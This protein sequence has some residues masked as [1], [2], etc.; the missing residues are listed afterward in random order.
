MIKR[1]KENQVIKRKESIPDDV[2]KQRVEHRGQD[3]DRDAVRVRK[4]KSA[5]D[6]KFRCCEGEKEKKKIVRFTNSETMRH[7]LELSEVRK[8]CVSEAMSLR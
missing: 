8:A 1:K 7:E 6:L 2:E 5:V 4:K 3:R